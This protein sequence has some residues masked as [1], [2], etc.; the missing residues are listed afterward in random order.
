MSTLPNPPTE[1]PDGLTIVMIAC[2]LAMTAGA[3]GMLVG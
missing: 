1:R 3:I 2:W